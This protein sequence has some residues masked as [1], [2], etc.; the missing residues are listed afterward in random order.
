MFKIPLN[1]S[2]VLHCDL[3]VCATVFIACDLIIIK[4]YKKKKPL[5]HKL[6]QL[7]RSF[8]DLN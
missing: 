4:C 1:I 2:I 5:N 7:Y 6:Q 3:I 8:C